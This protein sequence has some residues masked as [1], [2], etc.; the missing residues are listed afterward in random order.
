MLNRLINWRE[1][2]CLSHMS[3]KYWNSWQFIWYFR[4][5][6]AD[7]L[8]RP[9]DIDHQ[10]RQ[11]NPGQIKRSLDLHSYWEN[12]CRSSSNRSLLLSCSVWQHLRGT[13]YLLSARC[14][15]D[16]SERAHLS[17]HMC[18]I[19]AYT[20]ARLTFTRGSAFICSSQPSGRAAL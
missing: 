15:L 2:T 4:Y 7:I 17:V 6:S 18:P 5:E 11:P 12:N 13:R 3:D 14:H 10:R 9:T 20:A 16:A 1:P 8:Y 19:S